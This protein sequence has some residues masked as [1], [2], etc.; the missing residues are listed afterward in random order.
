MAWDRH[1]HGVWLNRLTG[2]QPSHLDLQRQFRYK[3]TTKL[4]R[5]RFQLIRLHNLTKTEK[6][7]TWRVQYQGQQMLVV[8][9]QIATRV[10][11][12]G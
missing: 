8:N 1:K 10:E 4:A 9:R 2:S 5:I 12:I 6:Q 11:Y 3:Q 7:Q